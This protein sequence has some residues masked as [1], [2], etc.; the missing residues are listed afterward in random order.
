MIK[1]VKSDLFG[2]NLN[3]EFYNSAN[4]IVDDL[5]KRTRT[6]SRFE[7][8]E[9]K[10]AH[11]VG[12][13][14]EETYRMLREGY[15]P[16]V[17]KMQNV[18]KFT[19]RGTAKRTQFM[20]HVEGFAPIVPNAIMGL[21]NS[22]ITSYTK[23]IK[24]KVIDVY[25]E[26][27]CSSSTSNESLI[28]AGEKLLGAITELE[29]QGYRFNLYVVQDYYNAREGCDMLCLRV[30]SAKQ[31]F[32]L[33]RMSFSMVHTAFF[34]GIGFEWYS[35]FPKG[36]YRNGYGHSISYDK[37]QEELDAEFKKLFGNNVV[38]FSAVKTMKQD[39]EYLKGVLTNG[40]R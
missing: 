4:D 33:K 9:Y 3:I 31:P 39:K 18:V 25:Y 20:N 22:M 8:D 10:N 28:K 35:K 21:P 29:A 19:A 13:T 5:Q 27:T 14:R 30:K 26:L 34:R 23:P 12:A 16:T 38:F 7:G 15:Q 32:D 17:D 1:T 6:D 36:K 11:W 24:T 40:K 37:S 2:G